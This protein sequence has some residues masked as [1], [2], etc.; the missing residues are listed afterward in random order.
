[1][2][3]DIFLYFYLHFYFVT[4]FEILFYV[5][6]IFPYENTLFYQLIYSS[7]SKYITDGND[8][9]KE[10][11]NEAVGNSTM[12]EY[13]NKCQ[14]EMD[15]IYY[16][17]EQLFMI[18]KIYIGVT[19]ATFLLVIIYDISRT[20]G[21][22]NK[23]IDNIVTLDGENVNNFIQMNSNLEEPEKTVI[24]F[25]EEKP[26]KTSHARFYFKNSS[27]VKEF[28]RTSELILLIGIFEYLFFNF[29]IKKI[30]ITDMQIILCKIVKTI[31]S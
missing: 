5:Y 27:L 4:L 29:I 24:I 6:Y 8:I 31:D 28:I 25:K 14:N 10:I 20:K 11:I 12:T 16:Y 1:M 3:Y 21:E 2:V 17:D 23:Y 19:S 18:C 15:K 22:Y 26:N 13:Y 9:Y 7:F 30:K